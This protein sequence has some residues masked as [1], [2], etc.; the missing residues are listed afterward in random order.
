M[1][2]LLT[3]L[4]QPIV[5]TCV[6]QNTELKCEMPQPVIF[7]IDDEGS[8]RE[9]LRELLQEE[10]WSVEV[11]SSGETF[12]ETYRPFR[13]GCLV[14]DA[15]MPCMGGIE[16]LERLKSRGRWAAGHHDH[17]PG[18]HPAGSSSDEGRG[19]GFS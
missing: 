9:A 4:R 15:Q 13:E 8:V 19:Y 17:R 10:G 18:R 7:V 14:V 12:L 16:L 1:Q 5:R 11:Y 3:E 2:S 6:P